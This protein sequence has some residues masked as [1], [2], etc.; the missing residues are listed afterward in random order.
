M[1]RDLE[2]R[3]AALREV[4]DVVYERWSVRLSRGS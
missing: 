3:V 1:Q 4:A 2:R